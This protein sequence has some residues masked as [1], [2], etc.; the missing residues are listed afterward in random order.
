M[1]GVVILFINSHLVIGNFIYNKIFDNFE[2]ELDKKAFLYGCIKPDISTSYLFIP[3]YMDK[4]FDF[5]SN[6]IIKLE[7]SNIPTVKKSMILYST[8]LG[9]VTHYIADYFCFPHNDMV[10]YRTL[11]HFFYEYNLI[12]EFN[13]LDLNDIFIKETQPI[14][15]IDYI[16][17]NHTEYHKDARGIKTDVYFS[18]NICTNSILMIINQCILNS[19]NLVA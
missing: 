16:I 5:I 10:F 3:H 2:V 1:Q 4:S 7:S 17:K 9:V 14:E 19:K 18:T 12:F 11:N 13:K 15:I 8:E 6:L